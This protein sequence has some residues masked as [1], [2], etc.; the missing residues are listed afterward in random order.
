MG[1]QFNPVKACF[2]CQNTRGSILIHNIFD[3]F[4]L[5]NVFSVSLSI[6]QP[7]G[8]WWCLG[9][10]VFHPRFG[11]CLPWPWSSKVREQDS[12]TPWAWAYFRSGFGLNMANLVYYLSTITGVILKAYQDA[13]AGTKSFPRLGGMHQWQLSKPLNGSCQTSLV[14][15]AIQRHAGKWMSLL[16]QWD[17]CHLEHARR[18]ETWLL[19]SAFH[20]QC[21]DC[22]S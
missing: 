19:P 17:P 22:V 3:I 14:R 12:Y 15:G 13:M 9:I 20:C 10:P 21:S 11:I 6:R 2:L 18:N 5:G 1:E 4:N 7:S 8:D 16:R